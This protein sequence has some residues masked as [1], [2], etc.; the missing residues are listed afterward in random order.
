MLPATQKNENTHIR[1]KKYYALR[2][3]WKQPKSRIKYLHKNALTHDVDDRRKIIAGQTN[4]NSSK[5]VNGY[6]TARG[7]RECSIKTTK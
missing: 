2:Q 3:S 5:N 4:V 7:K 1:N 6:I